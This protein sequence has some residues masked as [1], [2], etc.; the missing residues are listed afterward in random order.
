MAGS[1][2]GINA[3]VT[4]RNQ[5]KHLVK[6]NLLTSSTSDTLTARY[7][8]TCTACQCA[9]RP[10]QRMVKVPAVPGWLHVGDCVEAAES[11]IRAHAWTRCGAYTRRGHPCRNW[12]TTAGATACQWH[13]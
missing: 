4:L 8:G 1:R 9:I 3:R 2:G 6:G 13:A 5:P 10:G 11:L 12:V 7:A